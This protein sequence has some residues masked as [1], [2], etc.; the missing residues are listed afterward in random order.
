MMFPAVYFL[1]SFPLLRNAGQD[2]RITHQTYILKFI[3]K[4]HGDKRAERAIGI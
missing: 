3:D 4:N 2:K 1:M